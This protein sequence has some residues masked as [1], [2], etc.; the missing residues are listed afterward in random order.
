V[1]S[2]QGVFPSRWTRKAFQQKREGLLQMNDKG[3]QTAD[4]IDQEKGEKG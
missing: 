3:K 4:K 2:N 1:T